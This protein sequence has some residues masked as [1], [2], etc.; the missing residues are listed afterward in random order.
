MPANNTG[1]VIIAWCEPIAA[2]FWLPLRGLTTEQRCAASINSAAREATEG[3]KRIHE[4]RLCRSGDRLHD[5]LMAQYLIQ[6]G[7]A[8]IH[9][10]NTVSRS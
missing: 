6:I 2:L 10:R 9:R 1:Q 4:K 5:P 8:L 3:D 7:Q